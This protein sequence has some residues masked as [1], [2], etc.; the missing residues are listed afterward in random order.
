MGKK[1][2]VLANW[3]YGLGKVVVYTPDA[4]ARWSSKWINWLKFNKFWSQVLRW[5]MKD[6]SKI[7]YDLNVEAGE[8]AVTLQIVP[9]YF[10]LSNML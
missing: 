7:D 4:D 1:D 6:I 2:P 3:R 10:V 9:L 5:S 8:D